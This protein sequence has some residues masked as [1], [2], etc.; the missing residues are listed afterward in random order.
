ML[1]CMQILGTKY[2]VKI[3]KE[4]NDYMKRNNA[5][6]YTDLL[7]K[8]IFILDCDAKDK[9]LRHEIVHAFLFESGIHFG[10]LFH[11]EEMVEWLALQIPKIVECMEGNNCL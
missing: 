9:I 1:F 2:K 7:A 10:Y 4:G 5:D 11:N 8:E 6:G 3:L